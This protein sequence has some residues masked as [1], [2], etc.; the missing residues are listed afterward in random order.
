ME[1]DLGLRDLRIESIETLLYFIFQLQ[2]GR[3][4]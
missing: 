1:R 4:I 2:S 3:E